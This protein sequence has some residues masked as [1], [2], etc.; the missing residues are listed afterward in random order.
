LVVGNEG[1]KREVV[2]GRREKEVVDRFLSGEKK[3]VVRRGGGGKRRAR[4]G[5]WSVTE[6]KRGLVG[7]G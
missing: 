2:A 3:G 6:K 1:G 7:R 5:G 4:V